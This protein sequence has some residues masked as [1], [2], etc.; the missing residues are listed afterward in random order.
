MQHQ[1]VRE[2]GDRDCV[3]AEATEREGPPVDVDRRSH[4][5][6][7]ETRVRRELD[8]RR[9]QDVVIMIKL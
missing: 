3:Q 6:G 7:D 5:E 8:N 9:V 2:L 4:R 1:R